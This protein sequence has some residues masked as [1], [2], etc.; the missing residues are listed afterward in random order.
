MGGAVLVS[1][2]ELLLS[3]LLGWWGP[4]AWAIVCC[5]FQA[6]SREPACKWGSPD[7]NQHKRGMSARVLS[8]SNNPTRIQPFLST[9]LLHDEHMCLSAHLPFQPP[10]NNNYLHSPLANHL[11]FTITQAKSPL[12]LQR[13]PWDPLWLVRKSS[14]SQTF[15]MGSRTQCNQRQ[16]NQS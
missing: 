5:Y 6:I 7:S 9:F 14:P 12:Q 13:Q 4:S 8:Q 10:S 2:Q 3:L 16:A 1:S 15:M 11:S